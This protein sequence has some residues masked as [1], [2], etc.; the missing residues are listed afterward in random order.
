MGGCRCSYKNCKNN[1]KMSESAHFFHYPVKQKERCKAW[2]E[3]AQKPEYFNLDE[4]Q[5]RNKV[6]CEVHFQDECFVN[7]EK[8]R[9]LTTAV[10]T[11]DGDNCY[12]DQPYVPP[13]TKVRSYIKKSAYDHKNNSEIDDIKLVPANEDGTIFVLDSPMIKTS[14]KVMS[15]T[16]Q[17]DSL[18]PS[19]DIKC[20]STED[21]NCMNTNNPYQALLQIHQKTPKP[22]VVNLNQSLFGDQDNPSSINTFIKREMSPP[23]ETNEVPLEDIISKTVENKF[24]QKLEKHSKELTQIKKVLKVKQTSPKLSKTQVLRY[25]KLRIPSTLYTLVNLALDTGYD[26]N[27]TDEVFFKTIYEVSPQLYKTLAED[28]KWNI[29]E[30]EDVE[31]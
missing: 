27:E 2:I 7:A 19:I 11:L 16:Y 4:F 24:L 13:P 21:E 9:L 6:V 26:L 12:D 20:E 5:L 14:K 8:K 25:L 18:V 1:T 31:V 28:Y 15:Y 29:P 23:H 3:N 30:I 22:N 10:P 17:D